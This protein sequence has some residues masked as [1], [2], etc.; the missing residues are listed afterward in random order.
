MQ[1]KLNIQLFGDNNNDSH[2]SWTNYKKAEKTKQQK[3]YSKG[4]TYKG[5]DGNYYKSKEAWKAQKLKN[6][7]RA[8]RDH[9][10]GHGATDNGSM[11]GDGMNHG[12]GW[13]SGIKGADQSMGKDKN[14]GGYKGISMSEAVKNVQNIKPSNNPSNISWGGAPNRGLNLGGNPT[15][16]QT[17]SHWYDSPKTVADWTNHISTPGKNGIETKLTKEGVPTMDYVK[18]MNRSKNVTSDTNIS[19]GSVIGGALAGAINP[20]L[21]G[22]GALLGDKLNPEKIKETRKV[23]YSALDE[24]MKGSNFSG[25]GESAG[26]GGSPSIGDSIDYGKITKPQEEI[27]SPIEPPILGADNSLFNAIFRNKKRDSHVKGL[28][29]V[30]SIFGRG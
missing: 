18:E 25:I 27:V 16:E 6:A 1:F 26:R 8:M 30:M 14:S 3:A 15:K 13:G 20:G 17:N 28:G 9:G 11:A 23:G 19:Q 21:T 24:A 22:L 4:L 2:R 10:G 5:S 29:D 12:A 7:E